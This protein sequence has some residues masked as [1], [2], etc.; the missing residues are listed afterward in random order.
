MALTATVAGRWRALLVG[1]GAALLLLA[2]PTM[3]MFYERVFAEANER[4]VP[5]E[6]IAWNPVESP[7]FRLWPAARRQLD[8]A[9]AVDVPTLI[10][11]EGA[12]K[13]PLTSRAMR[14]VAVWWWFLPI[15]G[16]PRAVGAVV[17]AVLAGAGIW[18]VALSRPRGNAADR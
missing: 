6:Q 11:S 4:G 8:E 9:L 1:S 14:I 10:A 18:L 13:T 7:L 3:G 16:I 12:A 2:L 5:W 17:A 15:G